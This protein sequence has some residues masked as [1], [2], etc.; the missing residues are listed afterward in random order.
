MSIPTTAQRIKNE[1]ER[2][3]AHKSNHS[4]LLKPKIE[5]T[6]TPVQKTVVNPYK[7]KDYIEGSNYIPSPGTGIKKEITAVPKIA[8]HNPYKKL[9]S[10]KQR[11]NPSPSL[12]PK[13][14]NETMTT[15]MKNVVVN[16]Y[17]KIPQGA[18]KIVPEEQNDTKMYSFSKATQEH[19]G[20]KMTLETDNSGQSSLLS[21]NTF[22]RMYEE[23]SSSDDTAAGQI[24]V[25]LES[26]DDD[27]FM[28]TDCTVLGRSE[29]GDKNNTAAGQISIKLESQDDDTFM[30]SDKVDESKE[31]DVHKGWNNFGKQEGAIMHDK[32]LS[33]AAQGHLLGESTL[34]A[35]NSG[36]SLLTLP[37]NRRNEKRG[38]D[39]DT[40]IISIKIEAQDGPFMA[41]LNTAG[42]S[43]ECDTNVDRNIENEAA[44]TKLQ[45]GMIDGDD[46]AS[47]SQLLEIEKSSY[48]KEMSFSDRILNLMEERI[49][50]FKHQLGL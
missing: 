4:K 33:E 41:D 45:D 50:N 24:S 46:D 39:S 3:C 6:K 37:T 21:K 36:Q 34:E 5:I 48:G 23:R 15:H 32:S 49:K 13:S 43:E 44:T 2:S 25:K 30:G 12:L 14:G 27:T 9:D 29:E 1:R 31:S 22:E 42:R 35:D 40:G 7:K 20:G 26:Q 16:P 47:I 11:S 18:Q 10:P 17:K 19:L 38:P 28:D 8:T